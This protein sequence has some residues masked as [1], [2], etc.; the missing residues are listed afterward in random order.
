MFEAFRG[1]FCGTSLEVFSDECGSFAG[2]FCLNKKYTTYQQ[3]TCEPI[4]PDKTYET[5]SKSK[6]LVGKW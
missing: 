3:P 5:P 6:V 2:E 4:K 1:E